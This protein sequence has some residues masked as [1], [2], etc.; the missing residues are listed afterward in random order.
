MPF[1][2]NTD[3]AL[4]HVGTP[5]ERALDWS[6]GMPRRQAAWW[7]AIMWGAVVAVD[8]STSPLVSLSS[9]YLLPLCFTTW[10]FGRRVGLLAGAS[11]VAATIMINGFGDGLSAQAST[12][13]TPIAV[14]NSGI[15]ISAVI[16]V[17]MFVGAFRATFDRERLHARIDPLTGLGNRRS[18]LIESRKLSLVGMH[19][20]RV[21]LCGLIDLDD[22]KSVN[23]SNGHAAG[24]ATLQLAAKAL[25]E[26]LRPY[27]ATAR[28]G[29]DEFAFCLMVR[30]QAKAEAKSKEIHAAV[31]AALR[32]L[33]WQTTCS[34]GASAHQ[35]L[36]AA[37]RVADEALYAAKA[38]GKGVWRFQI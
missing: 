10:C 15:R 31:N 22:F 12:V 38:A 23:D 34:L 33:R 36:G 18:F 4:A 2:A 26:A 9:F 24:D 28:I 8:A 6:S 5:L 35:D 7:L 1:G 21:M 29:G 3:D 20:D 17:I 30:N 37:F 13:P 19:G 16:F 25:S 11:A 32:D 27:D 14:W